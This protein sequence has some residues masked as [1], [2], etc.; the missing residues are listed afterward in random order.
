MDVVPVPQARLKKLK[1]TIPQSTKTG[2]FGIAVLGKILVKTKVRTPIMTKG[3]TRD[4][5]IPKDM[6]R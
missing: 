4:Q 6:F 2:N 3:L 1:G 5:K